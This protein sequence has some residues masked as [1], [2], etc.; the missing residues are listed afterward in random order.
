MYPI[1]QINEKLTN[2]PPVDQREK[3]KEMTR[4]TIQP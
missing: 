2:C 4:R 3:K 1:N